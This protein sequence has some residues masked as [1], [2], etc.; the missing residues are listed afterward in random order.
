MTDH[1]AVAS[2]HQTCRLPGSRL[3]RTAAWILCVRFVFM[4]G[5]LAEPFVNLS[6]DLLVFR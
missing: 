6:C 3:I 4:F 1:R 2:C 5:L